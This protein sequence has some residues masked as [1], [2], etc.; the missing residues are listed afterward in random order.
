MTHD[1]WKGAA[2]PI[3]DFNHVSKY[4][5]GRPVLDG[6]SLTITAGSFVALVGASGAGK[7]TLL[8]A[9]N[10]L[11]EIDR[12]T[13]VVNGQDV[14]T[15][16]AVSLR[17]KIG[18]AFQGVGL[19]PHMTVAENV[20]LVP[21][22]AGMAASGR[23]QRVAELLDMVSL[24]VELAGRYPR[25]LSGGQAQRVGFARALAAGPSIMLMDEPF[26]AL[27]PVTRG[28]IGP[29]YRVLHERMGL[30]SLLVT[31]DMA[32][33]LILAD[34]VIILE[35][36]RVLAD[37][38]PHALVRARTNPGVSAMVD[39]ARASAARLEALARDA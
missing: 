38:T 11:V 9:V 3:I 36:G 35:E 23:E 14:A 39:A 6:I 27:D 26:G 32:E 1:R 30:T 16:P 33:A 31:H 34:R 18:Y 5:D 12:G 28:D 21:R 24:P 20:W 8:K 10:R 22:L 4:Y 15:Q 25:Q 37:M 7:T 29:A 13:V 17:R 19:F 2:V